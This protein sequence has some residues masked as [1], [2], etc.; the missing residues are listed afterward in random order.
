MLKKIYS[1]TKRPLIIIL[2]KYRSQYYIID[3]WR[4]QVAN[5]AISYRKT[6]FPES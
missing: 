2:I 5:P 1:S 4:F 3:N 6:H